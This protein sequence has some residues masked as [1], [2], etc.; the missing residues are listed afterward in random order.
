M[1]ILIL[2]DV[3]TKRDGKIQMSDNCVFCAEGMEPRCELPPA[4]AMVRVPAENKALIVDV[5]RN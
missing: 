3:C 5:L 1:R 2:Q 4:Q